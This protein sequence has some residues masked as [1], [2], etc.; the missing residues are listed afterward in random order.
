MLG[1]P[2]STAGGAQYER[3]LQV[4]LFNN[5][6]WIQ[7]FVSDTSYTWLGYYPIGAT[8]PNINFKF[9]KNGSCNIAWYGEVSD[10]APTIWN[11]A[12]MAAGFFVSAGFG[13]VGYVRN[14][15]NGRAS[16]SVWFVGDGIFT[17]DPLCYNRTAVQ[18]GSG[19]W[20][21]YF[22]YG[23]PGYTTGVAG[24]CL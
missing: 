11:T 1:G 7:D 6:W 4:V 24:T 15:V 16:G 14:M 8:S 18:V 3:R 23:G 12:D 17:E 22:Y 19:D 2:Y 21:R 13:K 5:A 20:T 9:I 10:A